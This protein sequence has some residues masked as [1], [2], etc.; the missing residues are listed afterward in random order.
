MGEP[1]ILL[2][3]GE[4]SGDLHGSNLAKKIL[5]LAPE[6]ELYGMGGPLMKAAGVEVLY[7]PTQ[8]SIIGFA[9]AV[10]AYRSLRKVLSYME[11]VLDERRPDIVVLIDF[12]GFN[13]KFG[14]LAKR[15][16]IPVVYY[17]L[18]TAW[19]WGRGRAK[20]VAGFTNRVATVFPFEHETYLE[21]GAKAEF[22]GHPLLDIVQ[23]TKSR[24]KLCRENGLDSEKPIVGLL[25]GSRRQELLSL[26]PI[27][28]DAA[29]LLVPRV[30]DVQFLVPLAHT[31][32][33][34]LLNNMNT[35]GLTLRIVA[36]ETYNV[37]AAC[38]AAVIA[39]G[40]ATLEAALLNIPLVAVYQVAPATYFIGR[41]LRLVKIDRYAL[42]NIIADRDVVPELIQHEV[43]P[44]KI[45]D[46]LW[47]LL[48]SA[49]VRKRMLKD[50]QEIRAK[51]GTSGAVSRVAQMVLEVANQSKKKR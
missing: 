27:M 50:Y 43:T 13:M 24:E 31:V 22:V 47:E 1:K 34:D 26:F 10:K 51:L 40:T 19:A 8:Q 32:S 33:N 37:L 12:P 30:P 20:K 39:C 7:D 45:A 42:P 5:E 44:E 23:V 14:E 49:D 41:K 4:A 35:H 16:D 11:R 2:M 36:G 18:P 29:R 6:A 38:D 48:Y 3:V 21:A 46:I 9:E 25:P 15:R 17:L 28:L